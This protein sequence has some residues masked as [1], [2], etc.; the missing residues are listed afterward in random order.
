VCGLY[1]ESWKCAVC[2]LVLSNVKN[3]RINDLN[4][5]REHYVCPDLKNKFLSQSFVDFCLRVLDEIAMC[6]LV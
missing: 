3:N 2:W 1:I 4:E 6:C 5:K